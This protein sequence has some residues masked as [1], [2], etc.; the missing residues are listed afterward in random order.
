MCEIYDS[1]TSQTIT[2]KRALSL[3]ESNLIFCIELNL[4]AERVQLLDILE[5]SV[6][7]P[8]WTGFTVNQKTNNYYDI[9]YNLPVVKNILL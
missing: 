5:N 4:C 3:E 8:F 9:S 7:N 1:I 2:V 6:R